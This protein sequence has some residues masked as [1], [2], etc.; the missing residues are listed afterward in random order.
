M[1]I[2]DSVK[3]CFSEHKVFKPQSSRKTSKEIFIIGRGSK[4][5]HA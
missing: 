5:S 1:A 4:S 3:S 2:T